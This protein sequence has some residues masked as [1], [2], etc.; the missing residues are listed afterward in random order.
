MLYIE[1]R[2]YNIQYNIFLTLEK[3]QVFSILPNLH[4][5][6]IECEIRD[7]KHLW[8]LRRCYQCLITRRK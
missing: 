3:T 8:R 6:H 5:P 7:I 1:E 2:L 4:R